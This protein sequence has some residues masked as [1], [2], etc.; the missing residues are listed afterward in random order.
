MK[1]HRKKLSLQIFDAYKQTGIRK[2]SLKSGITKSPSINYLEIKKKSLPANTKL[3]TKKRSNAFL[4][5][6]T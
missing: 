1:R 3:I 4:P 5:K 6:N 2:T